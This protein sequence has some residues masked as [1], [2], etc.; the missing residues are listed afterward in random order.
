[1][2]QV[3]TYEDKSIT[4]I[5]SVPETGVASFKCLVL[6]S[7][8]TICPFDASLLPVKIIHK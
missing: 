4:S 6:F 5:D 8:A 1:M 3:L 2:E 7:V